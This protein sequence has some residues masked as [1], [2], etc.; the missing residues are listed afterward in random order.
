MGWT[1]GTSPTLSSYIIQIFVLIC[2]SRNQDFNAM[3]VIPPLSVWLWGNRRDSSIFYRCVCALLFFCL[4]SRV[5]GPPV[6]LS[7]SI[8]LSGLWQDRYQSVP[9]LWLV[10]CC[11]FSLFVSSVKCRKFSEQERRCHLVEAI[12]VRWSKWSK[13]RSWGKSLTNLAWGDS[14]SSYSYTVADNQRPQIF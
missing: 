6:A 12:K 9:L 13:L 10:S 7:R 4:V 5:P 14:P 11:G 1:T 3:I 2:L 8:I